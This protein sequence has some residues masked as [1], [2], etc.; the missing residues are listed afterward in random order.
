MQ[1]SGN[2]G[3]LE[4]K[5]GRWFTIQKRRLIMQHKKNGFLT[6]CFSCLPGA[7]QMF[8]GF[9]KE[10]VSL[11]TIFFGL[12]ALISWVR[13]D[14]VIFLL[15]VVWCYAFFDAMNKDSLPDEEFRKLEDHYILINALE[16]FDVFFHSKYKRVVLA[17]IFIVVG[18][19]MLLNNLLLLLEMS[20]IEIP[21][22]VSLVMLEYVPQTII[23]VL[24]IMAGIYLIVFKKKTLLEQEQDEE[25]ALEGIEKSAEPD[26][27]GDEE[28][29]RDE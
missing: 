3:I 20:G 12:I 4:G 23:S 18:F 8:M 27:G 6:F 28:W 22:E 21:Y 2:T 15:P 29:N 24:I 7:G 10:G 5:G 17:I 14:S 9:T 1:D 26:L 11:M 13:M 25:A 19:H 16:E